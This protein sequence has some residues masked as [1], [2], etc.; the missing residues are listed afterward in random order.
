[1]QSSCYNIHE[2]FFRIYAVFWGSNWHRLTCSSLTKA[3]KVDRLQFCL[4]AARRP[5]LDHFVVIDVFIFMTSLQCFNRA[6]NF[7]LNDQH[8][9]SPYMKTSFMHGVHINSR[10]NVI[11]QNVKELQ[12]FISWDLTDARVWKFFVRKAISCVPIKIN[13]FYMLHSLAL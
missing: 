13:S 8:S 6:I 11:N 4:F 5:A 7:I 3:I 9:T 2:N 12:W 1:M 10:N